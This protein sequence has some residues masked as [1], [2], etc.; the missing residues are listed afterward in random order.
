MTR[1]LAVT[2]VPSAL[3]GVVSGTTYAIQNKATTL[4]HVATAVD[5]PDAGTETEFSSAPGDWLYAT[6]PAG[7]SIWVWLSNGRGRV[8][9]QDL[10]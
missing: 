10:P 1:G 5:A 6:A 7:E 8:T 9:Y 4:L 2:S 3:A